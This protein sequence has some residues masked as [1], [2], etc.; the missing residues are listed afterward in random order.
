MKRHL[1]VEAATGIVHRMVTTAANVPDVTQAGKLLHG[2][3]KRVWGDGGY[4]GVGKG[5]ANRG[6][7]VEWLV[8]LR[9]GKRRLLERGGLEAWRERTQ[10]SV[11]AKVEHSF[12]DVKRIFGYDQV[13]Y[14]GL[15]KNQARRAVL[16]GIANLMRWERLLPTWV[17]GQWAFGAQPV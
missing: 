1:G 3:E 13:R 17:R 4:T 14:W 9:P 6:L 12:L 15:A 16:L 2:E 10:A 11:R 7:A 5:E 8:A